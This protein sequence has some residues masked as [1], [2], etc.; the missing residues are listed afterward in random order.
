MSTPMDKLRSQE[1]LQRIEAGI[2]AAD[3]AD[4]IIQLAQQAGLDVTEQDKKNK[5]NK[6]QLLRIKNTFFPGT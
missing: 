3:E 4:A 6:T 2:T 1:Q 5:A